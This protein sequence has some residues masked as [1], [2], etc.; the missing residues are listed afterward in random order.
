MARLDA[1]AQYDFVLLA[2]PHDKSAVNGTDLALFAEVV[3]GY[4]LP[5][6]EAIPWCVATETADRPLV[7]EAGRC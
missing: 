5:S 2:L 6:A 7:D 4:H 3:L 1:S